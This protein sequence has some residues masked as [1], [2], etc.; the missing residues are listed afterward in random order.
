MPTSHSVRPGLDAQ[1]SL[2]RGSNFSCDNITGMDLE[3]HVLDAVGPLCEPLYDVFTSSSA[4]VKER[5]PELDQPHT[6]PSLVHASRGLAL[7]ALMKADLGA[8]KVV[9]G[10][11]NCG[12][13]LADPAYRM[14]LL[15]QMPRG[16][17][18]PP[19][20]NRARQRYYMNK[21]TLD[22]E[23][24]PE[25]QTLLGLW[26]CYPSGTVSIRV[27]R[28]VGLWKFGSRE[29]VDLDFLLPTSATSLED[30]EFELAD[31]EEFEVPIEKEAE[32]DDEQP[33]F[34]G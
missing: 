15:H 18:P 22:D 34:G 33:G 2:D 10:Q 28:P 29:K 11:P 27:V 17:A 32:G 19:G 9:P 3:R 1:A 31:E 8:W 13:Q 23:M 30:L 16:D 26:T 24:F 14:R 5:L 21:P 7:D 25:I 12:I 6:S 4:R 20:R